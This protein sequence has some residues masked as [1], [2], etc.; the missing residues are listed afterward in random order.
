[1]Y[2]SIVFWRVG[3][4]MAASARRCPLVSQMDLLHCAYAAH[5]PLD[6]CPSHNLPPPLLE[7]RLQA[8]ALTHALRS[9]PSG[10][11][12]SHSTLRGHECS[13]S[14]YHVLTDSDFRGH[15]VRRQRF[16]SDFVGQTVISEV[17]QCGCSALTVI[18]WVRR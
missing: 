11:V 10:A 8:D 12:R 17:T 15:T 2:M 5:T 6:S 18:S 16:G 7:V 14:A 1:M 9:C 4:E 13:G 3:V